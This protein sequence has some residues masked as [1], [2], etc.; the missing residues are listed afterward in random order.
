MYF[1]PSLKLL[2][3]YTFN[4]G[5][6]GS[7]IGGWSPG[8]RGPRKSQSSTMERGGLTNDLLIPTDELPLDEPSVCVCVLVCVCVCVCVSVCVCVC[9]CVCVYVCVCIRVRVHVCVCV[10][11]HVCA[12]S[13]LCTCV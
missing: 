5:L 1:F 10:C 12:S 6:C 8:I 13:C 7:V 2:T 4:E 11:V 9:V 3:I